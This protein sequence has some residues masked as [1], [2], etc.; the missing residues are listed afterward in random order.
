ML[1]INDT[2]SDALDHAKALLAK[3]TTP[4]PSIGGSESRVEDERK[5]YITLLRTF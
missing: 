3:S 1:L 2:F 5:Q 4:T